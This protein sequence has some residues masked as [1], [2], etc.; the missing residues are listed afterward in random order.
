MV[1]Q[2]SLFCSKKCM[3][4]LSLPWKIM[5]CS[6]YMLRLSVLLSWGSWP[7]Q[8][9]SLALVSPPVSTP[10]FSQKVLLCPQW[11]IAPPFIET[12]DPLKNYSLILSK[13]Q[14]YLFSDPYTFDM[15]RNLL[16]GV[17][18]SLPDK[19]ITLESE[20]CEIVSETPK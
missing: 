1:L 4:Q 7:S 19:L 2:K 16:H 15:S 12:E 9:V 11:Y 6:V 13:T 5:E 14:M 3:Y 10:Q 17:K 20:D 18:S 8:T